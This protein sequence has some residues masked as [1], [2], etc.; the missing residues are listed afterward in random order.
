[1]RV[2]CE[3]GIGEKSHSAVIVRRIVRWLFSTAVLTVAA[4]NSN[5]WNSSRSDSWGKPWVESHR[6]SSATAS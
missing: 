6:R 4:K 1:M 3:K 5:D 2:G